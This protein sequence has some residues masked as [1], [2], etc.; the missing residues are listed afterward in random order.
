MFGAMFAYRPE[1]AGAELVRVTRPGGR[2]A[3]ANWIPDGFIGKLLRAH[4]T[5][6]PPPPG[7]PSP[8]EWGHEGLVRD[9]LGDRVC[10]VTCVRRTL[11][12]ASRCRPRP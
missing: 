5:L 7:V 8:L 2:V 3:M 4:T 1:R 12:C 6:V 9:R 10:S 11:S